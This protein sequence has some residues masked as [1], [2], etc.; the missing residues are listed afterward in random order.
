MK[1]YFVF[2]ILSVLSLP[3]RMLA[4]DKHHSELFVLRRQLLELKK[5]NLELKAS[6]AGCKASQSEVYAASI[7]A[8]IVPVLGLIAYLASL[9]R[10]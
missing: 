8:V 7:A 9:S 1:P 2:A 5:E 3:Q 4:D 10:D 6:I